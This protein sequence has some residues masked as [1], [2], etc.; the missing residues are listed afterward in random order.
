MYRDLLHDRSCPPRSLLENMTPNICSDCGIRFWE[1]PDD[2]ARRLQ[3]SHARPLCRL[4]IRRRSALNQ[5]TR[6]P[7]IND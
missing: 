4:C 3:Q 7:T 2:V 5:A 1:T 6:N